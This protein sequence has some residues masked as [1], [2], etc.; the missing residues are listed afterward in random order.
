MRETRQAKLHRQQI[1]RDARQAHTTGGLTAERN[2][3]MRAAARWL[4]RHGYEN[5]AD[6]VIARAV[7]QVRLNGL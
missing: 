5:D 6:L 4:V 7:A 3:R 2:G 1:A